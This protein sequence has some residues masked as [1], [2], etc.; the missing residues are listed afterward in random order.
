MVGVEWQKRWADDHS[1]HHACAALAS[2]SPP[3]LLS[4]VSQAIAHMKLLQQVL[5]N[6]LS[7]QRAAHDAACA[8]PVATGAGSGAKRAKHATAD[9]DAASAGAAAALAHGKD[10]GEK[11]VSSPA[12]EK[13]LQAASNL[14]ILLERAE[15]VRDGL[16]AL[17]IERDEALALGHV[18]Q[19][20]PA[21]EKAVH[22]AGAGR[23]GRAEEGRG[24]KMLARA[25]ASAAGSSSRASAEGDHAGNQRR[26]SRGRGKEDGHEGAEEL[27]AT[28]GHRMRLAR[29]EVMEV[30]QLVAGLV[31]PGGAE[32]MPMHE[33]LLF[34]KTK[35]L[36]EAL[37][38]DPRHKVHDALMHPE[39]WGQC[40]RRHGAAV[41]QGGG[42]EMPDA[43]RL[44]RLSLEEGRRMS[45][46]DWFN[47]FR[48]ELES[49]GGLQG[50]AGSAA[51]GEGAA[52]SADGDGAGKKSAVRA[53]GSKSKGKRARD[54]GVAQEEDEEQ[55][56][57][58]QARFMYAVT[59]LQVVGAFGRAPRSNDAVQRLIFPP[60]PQRPSAGPAGPAP[61]DPHLHHGDASLPARRE[62]GGEA[63]SLVSAF[64]AKKPRGASM[65]ADKA[66]RMRSKDPRSAKAPVP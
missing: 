24:R 57:M 66:G 2:C 34:K 17:V 15:E 38:A 29:S 3:A 46:P 56:A 65:A 5:G 47:N 16:S 21:P 6:L 10:E 42:V 55:V 28:W 33:A 27:E 53:K 25:L 14:S 40:E 26:G 49:A 54:E 45:M 7:D 48:S 20:Q 58:L 11:A 63:P 43:A 19:E 41:A 37:A 8:A 4:A 44:Y 32:D 60:P 31:P 64:R 12:P 23:A 39:Q 18:V 9:T 13:A 61:A 1:M 52:G 50:G 62:G 35:P 59:E 51:A 30:V 36:K 22:T